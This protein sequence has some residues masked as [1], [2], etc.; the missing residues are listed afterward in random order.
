MSAALLRGSGVTLDEAEIARAMELLEPFGDEAADAARQQCTALE[1]STETHT[2]TVR[3]V[4][5]VIA[6]ESDFGEHYEWHALFTNCYTV[7]DG[8]FDYRLCPF[9]SFTQ[10]SLGKSRSLGT[11]KGWQ[12]RPQEQQQQT[13]SGS[14]LFEE[15]MV[16][17]GGQLCEGKPRQ[18]RVHFHCGD[19]DK[20]ISVSEPATC[21]YEAL[22]STPSAC[23]K[24][25]VL[26][27]HTDLAEAAKAAGL[28]Y[29]PAQE[30]KELLGLKDSW[31]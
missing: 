25:S 16:F 24:E 21:M 29:E 3:E 2:A 15:A 4:E 17:S 1:E 18:A 8:G 6:L 26:K 23:S 27:R 19:E 10:E 11:Y 7:K 14:A 22:F 20:L 31:F 5:P 28:P 12:Q 9:A 30:V 13:S